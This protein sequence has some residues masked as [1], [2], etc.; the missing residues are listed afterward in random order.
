[1]ILEYLIECTQ[2]HSITPFCKMT[3]RET[4]SDYALTPD[5]T[6]C[7]IDFQSVINLSLAI[8]LC[9]LSTPHKDQGTM[10]HKKMDTSALRDT[11]PAF[12]LRSTSSSPQPV[13]KETDVPREASRRSG[14]HGPTTA[15]RPWLIH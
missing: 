13:T 7:F 12:Q 2:L 9:A 3:P 14:S 4:E 11:I 15:A 1:M 6:P 10:S 8:L 5:P